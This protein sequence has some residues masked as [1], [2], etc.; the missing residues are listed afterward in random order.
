MADEMNT[1]ERAKFEAWYCAQMRAAGYNADDGIENLRDGN[2]YGKDRVMLNGKWEGWQARASTGFTAADMPEGI[3]RDDTVHGETYYTAADMAT[4]AAQGFRDGA[5]SLAANAGGE[6]VAVVGSNFELY[7]A[8]SG[9][10]APLVE[11]HGIKVG[12]PL[13]TH[14]S[15][16]EGMAGWISVDERLPKCSRKPDS[17]GVEVLIWPP[18]EDGSR[19][20]FYGRRQSTNPNF[21]KYGA[22]LGHVQFWAYPPAPPLPSEAKDLT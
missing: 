1:D 12:S 6:P 21:Y 20:A 19:T 5:A 8:G 22:L 17:L 3:T 13:Y 11:K 16:P 18:H 7:W 15:P 4:A 9:P 10:I 14:P 2:H